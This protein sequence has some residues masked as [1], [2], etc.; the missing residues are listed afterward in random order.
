MSR[1]LC[2]P[3]IPKPR[4]FVLPSIA[5][6][7]TTDR[8]KSS[9]V[10]STGLMHGRVEQAQEGESQIADNGNVSKKSK[11]R[12]LK[13]I[14]R[15][16]SGA[17]TAV[18]NSLALYAV[19]Q[20]G[21]DV[22]EFMA[23]MGREMS[24]RET[25]ND[26]I[27][28]SKGE[29][30]SAKSIK[31]RS[32]ERLCTEKEFEIRSHLLGQNDAELK[33]NLGTIVENIR[34]GRRVLEIA[35]AVELKVKE[36]VSINKKGRSEIIT[37]GNAKEAE[38]N[39]LLEKIARA[40]QEI[41]VACC[42]AKGLQVDVQE[43][44]ESKLLSGANDSSTC[45][46]LEV[47]VH[48]KMEST[49][50]N[51]NENENCT[52]S[53]SPL[54]KVGDG[55]WE[56]LEGK[57]NNCQPREE[58]AS[59]VICDIY[60]KL[61]G[62][63][64]L[65]D[66]E[67]SSSSK[68]YEF[69]VIDRH[70]NFIPERRT[71]VKSDL[72]IELGPSIVNCKAQPTEMGL[73]RDI[74]SID[75]LKCEAQDKLGVRDAASLTGGTGT[76]DSADETGSQEKQTQEQKHA[77]KADACCCDKKK[78]KVSSRLGFTAIFRLR[79]TYNG[80]TRDKTKSTG[81]ETEEWRVNTEIF[82]NEDISAETGSAPEYEEAKEVN[83]SLRILDKVISRVLKQIVVDKMEGGKE[84]VR[85]IVEGGY[86][87]DSMQ[88]S[89]LS[90]VLKFKAH[91]RSNPKVGVDSEKEI[92]KGVKGTRILRRSSSHLGEVGDQVQELDSREETK[93]IVFEDPLEDSKC[94][95]GNGMKSE[96][97][98]IATEVSTD[99]TY[100]VMG[101]SDILIG[102][103][104]WHLNE[105][106]RHA[107]ILLTVDTDALALPTEAVKTF[108][109][110]VEK[111]GR[112]F[113][114]DSVSGENLQIS[115]KTEELSEIIAGINST[116]GPDPHK[117]VR[118]RQAKITN[119]ESSYEPQAI[120]EKL[121]SQRD[122]RDQVFVYVKNSGMTAQD[123]FA[124]D[125]ENFSPLV[126]G[127][128]SI[129][130]WKAQDKK[131]GRFVVIKKTTGDQ[132][133]LSP[134]VAEAQTGLLLS[135]LEYLAETL[136][137]VQ[138][139]DSLYIVT[140]HA[141]D[142][143]ALEFAK[144]LGVQA[145]SSPSGKRKF[146]AIFE[147]LL[148]RLFI[149]LNNVHMFGFYYGDVKPANYVVS[150]DGTPTLVDWGTV[151][152][153][154]SDG[155]VRFLG[156][157]RA[158]EAPEC[159][160]RFA[161]VSQKSDVYSLGLTVAQLQHAYRNPNEDGGLSPTVCKRRCLLMDKKRLA[162]ELAALL[163][164]MLQFDADQRPNIA[165][166]LSSSWAK[167]IR[168][169]HN[170]SEP[171]NF[172]GSFHQVQEIE[173]AVVSKMVKSLGWSEAEVRSALE[174]ALQVPPTS[175]TSTSNCDSATYKSQSLASKFLMSIGMGKCR[176]Q[177]PR[178]FEYNYSRNAAGR[179]LYNMIAEKLAR[180]ADPFF[181]MGE[182]P[183]SLQRGMVLRRLKMRAYG[184][185]LKSPGTIEQ[186]ENERFTACHNSGSL[187]LEIPLLSNRPSS[188]LT[189]RFPSEEHYLSRVSL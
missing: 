126:A 76:F 156:G 103:E 114:K 132:F 55:L 140:A 67:T 161:F 47:D 58:Q 106:A 33:M 166:A 113:S 143:T 41:F 53:S 32:I 28:K 112:I 119:E 92:E 186:H 170:L 69:S 160:N 128:Q 187:D 65:Y 59:G 7:I 74:R 174:R 177:C 178:M 62:T 1:S 85:K 149:G 102:K 152:Q 81:S 27:L 61:I 96:C 131:S 25:K 180:G 121:D 16:F 88:V 8:L 185:L 173:P 42:D 83:T 72:R 139:L 95:P 169:K 165:D 22:S 49:Q 129:E 36:D 3:S 13:P 31:P 137:V 19:A 176:G 159:R 37:G 84:Y 142:L 34:Q 111:G 124:A 12:V 134:N 10:V 40:E 4:W 64:E 150:E 98:D 60:G 184:G 43:K 51:D 44:L 73:K 183:Y 57:S 158:Y 46:I 105:S 163:K 39:E 144:S 23:G 82:L 63:Q 45:H 97:E 93:I 75:G 2:L 11:I 79:L 104:A 91:L 56:I 171:T 172:I 110:D 167:H 162:P 14:V 145:R 136:Q 135:G 115:N 154:L 148:Y 127:G 146:D 78:L 30:K 66:T 123:I 108:T 164:D 189:F 18:V 130:V 120:S 35:T 141:G 87:M 118:V 181:E 71:T 80:F 77:T 182:I 179:N 107:G 125:Y 155:T 38:V 188:G 20:G 109:G 29:F 122:H 153:A 101:S 24:T 5:S 50:E 147:L 168:V 68:D 6:K 151:L 17:A 157:T 99:A 15:V 52:G 21:G 90:S 100:S 138:T 9:R 117:I 133:T 86:T 70:D 26:G 89:L 54:M 94:Q 175:P 116:L 48:E